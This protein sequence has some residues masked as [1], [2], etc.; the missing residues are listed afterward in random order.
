MEYCCQVWP[1]ATTSYLVMLDKLQKQ[2][3]GLLVQQRVLKG[4][5]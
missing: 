3:V 1:G 5:T 4:I 2:Y